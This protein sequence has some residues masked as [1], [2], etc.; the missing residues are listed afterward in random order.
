MNTKTLYMIIGA[1]LVIV[2]VIFIL[3]SDSDKTKTEEKSQLPPGHPSI[4]EMQSSGGDAVNGRMPAEGSAPNKT[5]VRKDFV[6]MIDKMREKVNK[7][8][9][10]TTG[11]IE[12][13]QVLYDSHQFKEASEMFERFLKASP[14]NTTVMLDLSV[15][16]FNLGEME[17]AAKVTSNIIKVDSKNTVAMYNLGAIHA[18][19]GN[20]DKARE[21]WEKLM[22]QFP[23]S[24]DASRAKES[25][26]KL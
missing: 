18:T 10:D 1:V 24:E 15:C 26:T 5:N 14:K 7:N 20:K 2:V 9:N 22:K 17:H 3:I 12:F 25:L 21:V 6:H 4:G 23:Q 8:S 13:A 11:V 19:Q 16:Y